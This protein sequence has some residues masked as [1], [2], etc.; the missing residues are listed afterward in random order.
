MAERSGP[1]TSEV[2]WPAFWALIRPTLSGNRRER[3]AAAKIAYTA[4]SEKEER[5]ES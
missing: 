4:Y 5:C 2:T 3:R 1:P